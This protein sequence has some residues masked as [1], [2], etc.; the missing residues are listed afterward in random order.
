[1]VTT[2][3]KLINCIHEKKRGERRG[4]NINDRRG[5]DVTL[6]ERRGHYRRGED[7]IG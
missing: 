3:I 6:E 1:M 7:R 2:E 4:D 5:E